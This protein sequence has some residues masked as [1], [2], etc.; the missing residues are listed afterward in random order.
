MDE[1]NLG[2]SIRRNKKRG[3][4]KKKEKKVILIM[5]SVLLLTALFF[6]LEYFG[7]FP[8]SSDIM[9]YNRVNILI[10]GC[11]EIENQGRADTIVFLSISPKTKDVLI[12]SIPRDTRVEIPE[13]GM[14]KINHA[15]AFGGERLISKTVSSFLDVPIH[16]YA[17]VDF[18]GFVYII[19]EL[20]GVE[21]DVEK[22]M[23]YVDK[24][25]GVEINLYP[26]KQIL[27]GRKA[28][29]YIRFRYD[30]LGDLG[31]IKRQ[32][33]LAL[34][35]IKK[36][37]H[38][39]SITKIPQISEGMKE[40][41]ETNIEAQ[42]AIALANLFRGVNQEKFRVETVQSKPVYIEG[43]SYLEPN[44]EEVQQRVKSL[45]YSK[46]SGMKVEVLNGNAMAGIAHKIAKDLELQ[47]FEIVNIGNADNFNYEQTKI[48]V[49]SKEVNLDNQFK[50][51]FKDFE[52]AKEYQ[53][54]T[55]LDLVI[56]LGKDMID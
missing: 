18:I 52:I 39:D 51:L 25:G 14:D 49:Y 12:L 8:F 27:D 42:D 28:L 20:G 55:N 29:Q 46:N 50:E 26:G 17:V 3:L 10:I 34:T 56:I 13:R 47:G 1:N 16:F 40:Y 7:I 2:G 37:I 43:I 15:Y 53:D 4:K 54:Q 6:L 11:D 9:S 31:R 19:D 21:I 45:I 33:K 24:A 48:I 38:F 30:K 44:V 5:F 41:M 36:M 35:V 22:E 23:H 32:Q